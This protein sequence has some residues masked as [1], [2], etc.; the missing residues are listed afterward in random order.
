MKYICPDCNHNDTCEYAGKM[1]AIFEA[2]KSC[3][4]HDGSPA[5]KDA[6]PVD[7]TLYCYFFERNRDFT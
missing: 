6:Y 4:L 1:Y 5:T 3:K 7:I 2:I